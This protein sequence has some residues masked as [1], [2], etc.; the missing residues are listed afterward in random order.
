M[1]HHKPAMTESKSEVTLQTTPPAQ[2]AHS[3]S[4]KERESKASVDKVQ[5]YAFK[6]LVQRYSRSL[7]RSGYV[8]GSQALNNL[9][10]GKTTPPPSLLMAET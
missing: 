7:A 10:T 9:G 5:S 1:H 3:T 6:W 4:R 8:C 2:Y